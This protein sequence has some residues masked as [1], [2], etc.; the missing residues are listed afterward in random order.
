M[1]CLKVLQSSDT[2]VYKYVFE[3]GGNAIAEAVLYRYESFQKRTVLCIS[4]QSGCPVG[5]TF[6][7][8]GENFIRNLTMD[9][10][11]DQVSFTLDSRAIDT[12]KCDKFQ[13]M[14]M[15]MG[16]P[17]LNYNNVDS[18][19]QS[20]NMI[21]PNADLLV[22]TIAPD[23]KHYGKFIELSKGI[24]NLGLQFSIHK[25]TDEERDKLIPFNSKLT[26]REIR[27]YGEL[28]N[29]E[30]GRK[31]Y[32]NYCVNGENSY[33]KDFHRLA[34]LF[35]PEVFNMTFSVICA[36]NEN[37]KEAAF[38]DLERIETFRM[39]FVRAGYDTRVFDPAGQ[40]DIGGGCGQLWFVQK[41]IADRKR[42]GIL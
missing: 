6:C 32:L 28:W 23:S 4:I 19:I 27:D 42:E 25:S 34:R 9:E 36:P 20:L 33:E 24:G 10:I 15:S 21:Y 3:F 8:T 30:T 2:N 29:N 18:A 35:A 7:G 12:D 40:D 39:M 22:S 5:C 13:I 17:F 26:L 11:I 37:M 1:K 31:P 14:F 41:Y 16:E 38:R